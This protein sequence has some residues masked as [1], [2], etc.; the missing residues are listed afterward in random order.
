MRK[1]LPLAAALAVAACLFTATHVNGMFNKDIPIPFDSEEDEMQKLFLPPPESDQCQR[2]RTVDDSGGAIDTISMKDGSTQVIVYKP[3]P[4]INTYIVYYPSVGYTDCHSFAKDGPDDPNKHGRIATLNELDGTGLKSVH[5]RQYDPQGKLV[6]A[7][8]LIEGGTKSQTDYYNAEGL[9][10]RSETYDLVYN[11]TESET[12]YRADG[13]R[14]M[15]Q[16]HLSS[17]QNF[18]REHFSSD[19]KTLVMK[20]VRSHKRYAI[21]LMYDNGNTRVE[22]TQKRGHSELTFYRSD[23]TVELQVHLSPE[24]VGSARMVRFKHF[25]RAGKKNLESIWLEGTRGEIDA[26]GYRPLVLWRVNE[27]DLNGLPT[28]ELN[29]GPDGTLKR[30]TL[31]KYTRYLEIE[32]Q[33]ECE[34]RDKLLPVCRA[35]DFF[36]NQPQ[37][38]VPA[39]LTKYEKQSA[40]KRPNIQ[41]K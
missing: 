25:D 34:D 38:T 22:A 14:L 24:Q 1:L 41:T 9:I 4:R 2:I 37:F 10:T 23:R 12:S 6:R 33:F 21:S 28:R 20:E 16:S 8:N 26:N 36:R 32:G 18:E 17:E 7:S 5:F 35:P 15:R 30:V 40:Q 31:F 19:G 13:T 29:Y 11:V 39:G 3:L 27:V